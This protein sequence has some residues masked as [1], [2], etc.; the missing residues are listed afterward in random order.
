V[1]FGVVDQIGNGVALS[2]SEFSGSQFWIESEDLADEESKP[3]SHTFN[4]VKCE[5]DGPLT[6]D[7]G[8]EDTMNVFE[9]IL[10]VFDDQ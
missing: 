5:G 4:F 10:S 1:T 2:L 8:V 6:V 3:S 9:C 7:V